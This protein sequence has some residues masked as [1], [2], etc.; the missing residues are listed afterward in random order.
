MNP[1]KAKNCIR[2]DKVPAVSLRLENRRG[3]SRGWRWRSSNSTKPASAVRPAAMPP[4]VRALSQPVSGA[5]MMLKTRATS[6]MV[7]SSA[8]PVSTGGASGWEDSGTKRIVPAMATAARTTLTAKAARQENHSSRTPVH[9]SPSTALPPA[10]PARRRRPGC[11]R[12]A[13]TCR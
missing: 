4:K 11:A 7:A 3:S 12:R 5:W 1:K 8:P 9:S 13:G 2:M 6:P 10:T